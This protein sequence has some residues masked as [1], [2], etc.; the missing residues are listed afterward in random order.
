MTEELGYEQARDQLVE[1]VRDLEA[2]GLSLE[3]SLALWEK[4]EKLAKVC[5]RHLDG[6]RERVETALASVENGTD[7]AEKGNAG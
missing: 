5:E 7:T 1:V 2:G 3:Q 4:G 6:A